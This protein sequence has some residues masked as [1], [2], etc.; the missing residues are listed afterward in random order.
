MRRAVVVNWED[1]VGVSGN[2]ASRPGQNALG[3]PGFL[4]CG[5]EPRPVLPLAPVGPDSRVEPEPDTPAP[6]CMVGPKRGRQP[7]GSRASMG[8]WEENPEA[9]AT[10][11]TQGQHASVLQRRMT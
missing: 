3:T 6:T 4:Q 10:C 9:G 8:R 11:P 7:L 1:L 5:H 2:S